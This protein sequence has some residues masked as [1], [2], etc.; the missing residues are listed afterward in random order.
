[1]AVLRKAHW[2]VI[3]SLAGVQDARRDEALA[4]RD[5]LRDT[6]MRDEMSASLQTD[7]P[8]V[9]REAI[10]LLT[11]PRPPDTSGSVTVPVGELE[12]ALDKVRDAARDLSGGEV[13]ITWTFRP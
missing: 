5:Q 10:R 8:D 9:Q 4:L 1:V 7:L 2:E 12:S 13:T 3:R 11:T 6:A